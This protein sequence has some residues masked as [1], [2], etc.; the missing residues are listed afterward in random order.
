M[1]SRCF[2][3][4]PPKAIHQS[5]EFA[6]TTQTKLTETQTAVLNAAAGRPDGNIAR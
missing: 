3:V 2:G 5:S 1:A 6:M 4:N